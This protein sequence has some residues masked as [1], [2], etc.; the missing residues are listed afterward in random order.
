MDENH[1]EL[2]GGTRRQFLQG[3]SAAAAGGAVLIGTGAPA[4]AQEAG[5][6][7]TQ[8]KV[9][10][11]R[12]SAPHDINL[13]RLGPLADLPGTWRGK[14]FNLIFLPDFHDKKTFRLLLNATVETLDFT[15][16]GGPVPNRGSGQDDIMIHGLTYLQRVTDANNSGALHIEP[17]IWLHVPATTDPPVAS[18]T[19]VRQATIPHGDSLLAIGN[20]IPTINGGPQIDPVDPTPTKNP[21]VPPPLGPGY[22]DPFINPVLPPGYKAEYVKNPNQALLDAIVGETIVKTEVLKV[23]TQLGDATKPLQGILNI[24]FVVS[25]ANATRLDA[26]F[27]IETV[28]RA[29]GSLYLKLQYTQTVILFF[30]G[31]DWPHVSVATLVKQ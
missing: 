20:V 2:E 3:A 27:W 11:T 4:E 10:P 22:L 1:D 21:P 5:A 6:A 23:S 12:A 13:G 30:K 25:N 28:Q 9:E 19:V 14:G 26:I 29:D 16:I 8:Q 24:P 7:Q 17:G 31:I 15:P 18:A